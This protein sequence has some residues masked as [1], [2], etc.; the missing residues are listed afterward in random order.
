[1][2]KRPFFVALL[3]SC[4][5]H[6]VV[7]AGDFNFS[8]RAGGYAVYVPVRMV[9]E[10]QVKK[11]EKPAKKQ[12]KNVPLET[13]KGT[14]SA[15]SYSEN[16]LIKKYLFYLREEIEKNKYAFPGSRSYG[17]IGNVAISCVISPSGRFLNVR[18]A[19]DSGDELLNRTAIEAIKITDGTYR[20]PPWAGREPLPVIF[21]IKYQY[22]L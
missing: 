15:S 12:V 11:N 21:T 20:R 9:S 6:L 3:V 18:I 1:M 22:G 19:R 13:E 5:V 4:F 14:G 8:T 17:L 16:E 2:K 10:M 7:L